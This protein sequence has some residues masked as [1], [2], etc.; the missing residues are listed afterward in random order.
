M[1]RI[2]AIFMLPA[3]LLCSGCSNA[4]SIYSNY[5]EIEQM[6][7]V[8]T[9]GF[10]RAED[11]LRLSIAGGSG[12]SGSSGSEGSDSPSI[13]RMTAEGDSITSAMEELQDYADREELYYA[14]TQYLVVGEDCARNMLPVVLAYTQDSRQL[15]SDMPLFIVKADTA[16]NLVLHCGGKDSDITQALDSI[17]RDSEKRGDGYPFTSGD[18]VGALAEYGAALAP[19]VKVERTKTANE[20]AEDD[21]VSPIQDGFAILKDDKLVGYIPQE[22]SRGVNLLMG[23]IGSGTVTVETKEAG[24]VS[25]VFTKGKVELSPIWAEN[26][27]LSGIR[28]NIKVSASVEEADEPTKLNHEAVTAQF[29]ALLEDWV[30]QVLVKMS[31]TG[32]DFLGIGSHLRRQ[33]PSKWDAMP[34]AW[35]D[36]MGQLTF[37]VQTDCEIL[38]LEE[39]KD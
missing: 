36:V 1:K 25:L 24:T 13:T 2:I 4:G 32:A 27:N 28:A 17:V 3:L 35:E 12:S 5:R 9:L 31:A 6:Q 21:Q 30:E 23:E 26:G 7:L 33:D 39:L 29:S 37:D 19:A 38:R 16:E 10:D 34:T 20:S 11:K 18:I 14:H 8:R 22:V 15:R